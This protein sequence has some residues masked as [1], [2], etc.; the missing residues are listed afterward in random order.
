[1]LPIGTIIDRHDYDQPHLHV[2]SEL[3]ESTNMVNSYSRRIPVDS[4]ATAANIA[5]GTIG[6]LAT[7]GQG[8][9]VVTS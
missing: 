6:L 1:M 9:N 4:G 2:E 5:T 3:T 8:I 7:L